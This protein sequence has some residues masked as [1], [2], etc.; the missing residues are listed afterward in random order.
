[1]DYKR[2]YSTEFDAGV[3]KTGHRYRV[4]VTTRVR[5]EPQTGE[6]TDATLQHRLSEV[7]NELHGRSLDEM[8]PAVRP[9]SAGL[10]TY[11][12]ERLSL[13]HPRLYKVK[14]W[15]HQHDCVTVTR[16]IRE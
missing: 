4:E 2:S 9:T 10:A 8:L 11:F 1:M 6:T 7:C 12:M 14:V 5:Y 16:E 3:G 13:G 15:E